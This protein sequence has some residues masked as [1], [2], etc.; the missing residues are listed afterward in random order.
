MCFNQRDKISIQNYSSLKLVDNFTY[1]GG[2]V[3][4]TETHINTRLSNTWN[5]IDKL[6]VIWKSDLADN[7][8]FSFFS[9]SGRVDTAV[10]MHY[11]DINKTLRE[12]SW[13]QL[14]KNAASNTEKSWKLYPTKQQLYGHLQTITKTIK[15]RRTR[16]CWR[17]RDEPI[18]DVL[19]WTPSHGRAKAGRLTTVL[20]RYRM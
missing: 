15:I 7:M 12:I 5:A 18:S 2:S 11:M 4:S 13:R 17:R 10:W 19:L 6:S 3:S 16:H 14:H 1:L 20:C 8:K 9:S